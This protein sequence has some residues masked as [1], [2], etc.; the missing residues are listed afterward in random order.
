MRLEVAGYY[1]VPALSS[2]ATPERT[3]L[4]FKQKKTQSSNGALR[5]SFPRQML[6]L[7]QLQ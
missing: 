7:G 2:E 4:Y 5:Y 1:L 6:R 3:R